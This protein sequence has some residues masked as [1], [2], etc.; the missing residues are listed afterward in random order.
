MKKIIGLN[1]KMNLN[2]DEVLDYVR[3]IKDKQFNNHEIII[4]PSFIYL[5]KFKESNQLLG[6]QNVHQEDTGAFTGEVSP[7]QLKSEKINYSLVGH[8]ERRQ[9]F[10]ED[11]I[12]INKKIK[13]CLRNNIQIILCIGETEDQRNLNQTKEV[14]ERQIK[15]DLRD[16]DKESINNIVIAYEPVWAIGTG[17]TPT[18]QEIDEAIKYIKQCVELNCGPNIKVIY[19]GSVNKG[20]IVDIMNI[21]SVDGVLIGSAS[22]NPNDVLSMMDMID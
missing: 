1:L 12:L 3:I 9:H 4:F 5:D 13:G 19:G 14:L 15:E 11:D 7:M 8:S 22:N 16:I 21:S 17:K 20:N 2:H 18:N 10:K 6:A